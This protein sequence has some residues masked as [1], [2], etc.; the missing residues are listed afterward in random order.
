VVIIGNGIAGVTAA[1]YV[2][3]NHPD[4]EIHLVGRER[5][6]L[7][8][9]MAITRLIYGRS[10]MSGLYLQPE[11]WYAD[12]QITC[13]LN[14]H[15]TRLDTEHRQ[16]HLA[17][18]EDLAYDRLILASG[19]A[20]LVPPLPGF[21]LRE[22]DEAMEI[23]GYV[24]QQQCRQAV[25]AGGG[26]LGL[27]AAYALHKIGLDVVVLERGEWLL[28]RQLDARAA[29]L[30]EQYLQ[31]VG[32]TIVTRAE[33][34]SVQGAERLTQVTL[35]DGRV[36]PAEVFLVAI[37]IQPNV[38]LAR[39]AGL[40]VKRGVLVDGAMRTTAPDIFAAGDVCEFAQQVPGLW[41]VAVEQARVAAIN[42]TGGQAT[43]QTVIPVTAL[44][45][46]GVDMTSVGR[47]EAQSEADLEIALEDL[48]GHRYRKLV[49]NGGRLVG[50]ILLGY[51][52]EATAVTAAVKAGREVSADL[53][54]LRAGEWA[55]LQDPLA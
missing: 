48:E 19:S 26:L 32:V 6:H 2:R 43:Y 10:A 35:K 28:R 29:R 13:W 42:A 36:L 17:T 46:V 34:A 25:I 20:S 39:A 14:T 8:N 38:E 22:A 23:R 24:Q 4:C 21:G 9:R 7:Y 50:A 27:E 54:A 3:R 12:K 52:L 51:P 33:T 49:I 44:K 31:A 15:A 30:L 11:E 5:H 41:P 53:D 1:D 55:V 40:D 47:F 18:G 37:G 45:V 16:V